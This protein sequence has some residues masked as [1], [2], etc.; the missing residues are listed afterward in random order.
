MNDDDETEPSD[1]ERDLDLAPC[2]VNVPLLTPIE[3]TGDSTDDEFDRADAAISHVV[4]SGLLQGWSE[5]YSIDDLCKLSTATMKA[6]VTRR[7][8]FG[9]QK[10]PEGVK[11]KTWLIPIG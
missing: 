9:K 6:L 7:Q 11:G 4:L 5:V 1:K 3:I 10:V 8:L 2:I